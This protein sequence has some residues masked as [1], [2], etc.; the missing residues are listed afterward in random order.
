MPFLMCLAHCLTGIIP[1]G[2][3]QLNIFYQNRIIVLTETPYFV[4]CA[5]PLTLFPCLVDDR[6]VWVAA[7]M[8]PHHRAEC[9]KLEPADQKLTESLVIDVSRMESSDIRRPPRNTAESHMKTRADLLTEILPAGE[10]ISGP[11]QRSVS[12]A[13]DPCAAGKIYDILLSVFLLSFVEHT[14]ILSRINIPNLCHRACKIPVTLKVISGEFRFR[15]IQPEGFDPHVCVILLDLFPHILSGARIGRV[16]KDV[17][18]VEDHLHVHTGVCLDQEPLL[19][20][21]LIVFAPPVDLRPDG[22]HRLD[23]H[24]LQFL[25][26]CLRIREVFFV[27][28]VVT[29]ARP[30]IIVDDQHIQ[31]DVSLLVLPGNVQNLLLIV[32]AQ[33]A[34]PEAKS[35]LRHHRDSSCRQ[36]VF[37]LNLLWIVPGCDPVV[38]LFCAFCHPLRGIG[39]EMHLSDR[40][41]VPQESITEAGHIERDTRLGISVCQFQ[42][43][44]FQVHPLLL[45]LSHAVNL[46]LRI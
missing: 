15:L 37:F 25:Y 12:L 24:F 14:G 17:V 44:A 45:I 8:Q 13:S 4:V 9:S 40:R 22:N 38:Q 5:C 19:L 1:H 31:R 34:L 46:L 10:D 35:V 21:L 23:P 36:R 20:H 26:H 32:I 41:I 2:L 27:K 7:S 42:V 39:P 16:Q 28:A 33:F 29:A 43:A 3:A 6:T 18:S 11:Y 30:V